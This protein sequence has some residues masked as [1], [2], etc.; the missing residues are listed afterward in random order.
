[1]KVTKIGHA[2][3]I[4]EEAGLK[5]LIDPGNYSLVPD[6]TGLDV[7]LITHEHDDHCY[8]PALQEVLKRN[9]QAEVITHEAVGKKLEGGGIKWTAIKD[10]ETIERKG[11]KIASYGTK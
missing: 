10:G 7:V 9:P 4:V 5:A 6:A 3:L 8:L 11:V 1:M 2:C